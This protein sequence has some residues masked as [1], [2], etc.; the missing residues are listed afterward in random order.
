MAEQSDLVG[1]WRMES[2]TR[3]SQATGVV[4]DALGPDPVGYIA[5]HADG[6]MMATVFRSDRP[7]RAGADWSEHQKAELFDSM[8]AYVARYSL[9]GDRVIHHVERA[10]NPNWEIDLSRPFT[11]SGDRLT[12]SGAPG[13][14]PLTG[15]AVI[16]RME[17]VRVGARPSVISRSA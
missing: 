6:H 11:L 8:L 5:Y 17:F 16:Y 7:R 1:T 12:I 13:T 15:E 2:W 10:W 14:D 4:S 3:Q 9:E